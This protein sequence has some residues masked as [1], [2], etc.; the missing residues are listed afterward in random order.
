MLNQTYLVISVWHDK[1][2]NDPK[3]SI[4]SVSE[5]V[6]KKSGKPYSIAD[7]SNTT[8]VDGVYTLGQVLQYEMKLLQPS[9]APNKSTLKL[10]SQDS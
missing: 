5:G 4:A 9:P 10:G 6:S 7:T 3:A 2:T 8:V 1:Q